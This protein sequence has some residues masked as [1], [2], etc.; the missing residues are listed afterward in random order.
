M[1]MLLEAER[2]GRSHRFE[3]KLGDHLTFVAIVDEAS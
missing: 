1:I 3:I 2:I